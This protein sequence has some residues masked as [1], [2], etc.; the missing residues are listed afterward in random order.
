MI[1]FDFPIITSSKILADG[2]IVPL[3]QAA[4]F[5]TEGAG[6]ELVYNPNAK[7]INNRQTQ[8]RRLVLHSWINFTEVCLDNRLK[9][10]G[11]LYGSIMGE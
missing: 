5:E 9:S 7:Q 10:S 11:E 2:A 4:V 3:S 8:F 1:F 6:R